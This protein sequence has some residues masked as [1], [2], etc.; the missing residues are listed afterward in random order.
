MSSSSEQ[1]GAAFIKRQ[2]E[3]L[4]GLTS[5][6]PLLG[7]T[8]FCEEGGEPFLISVNKLSHSISS[9]LVLRL[10]QEKAVALRCSPPDC[11]E[12]PKRQP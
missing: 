4:L 2:T 5:S 1:P 10:Q 11:A 8:L 9:C 12:E 7:K 3:M 6:P